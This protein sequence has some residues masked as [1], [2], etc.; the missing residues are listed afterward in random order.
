MRIKTQIGHTIQ[1][2]KDRYPVSFNVVVEL[3]GEE[4]TVKKKCTINTDK[5]YH[6][7][8]HWQLFHWWLAE[9]RKIQDVFTPSLFTDNQREFLLSGITPAEWD[10]FMPPEDDE[11]ERFEDEA[12]RLY[13]EEGW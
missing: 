11:D 1:L 8:A 4:I 9:G 13:D 7:K 2:L 5:Y 6:V 3:D 10:A 12:D